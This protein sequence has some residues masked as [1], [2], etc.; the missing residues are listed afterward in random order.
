MFSKKLVIIVSL[1]LLLLFNGIALLISGRQYYSSEALSQEH[2]KGPG[3]YLIAVIAPFQNG[4][5]TSIRFAQNLWKHYFFLVSVAKE[6]EVLKKELSKYIEKNNECIEA[7][8]SNLRLKNIL[9]FQTTIDHPTLAAQVVGMDPS[10]WFQSIVINKGFSHGIKKGF[11]VVVP[12]GVIGQ[13]IE[14]TDRY[15]KVLLLTDRNSAIDALVQKT[16]ARGIIRGSS[17][18]QFSFQYV[19]GKYDINEGDTVISSG[20]DGVFPK[21]LR[22]GRVHSIVKKNS[23]IFQEIAVIPFV[24]FEK[25]EEVIVIL[26]TNEKNCERP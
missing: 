15:A 25:L 12:D 14:V 20:L 17:K 13:I 16:R 5:D 4:L 19:L 24:D 21:G 7:R 23:S 1:I 22:V 3:R 6:N 18:E 2:S 11:P 26:F 8:L 10:S 9:N